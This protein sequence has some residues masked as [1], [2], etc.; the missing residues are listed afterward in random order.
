MKIYGKNSLMGFFML[1]LPSYL[2]N[3]KFEI[4]AVLMRKI[5]CMKEIFVKMVF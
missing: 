4:Y 5:E 3:F 1:R 2:K